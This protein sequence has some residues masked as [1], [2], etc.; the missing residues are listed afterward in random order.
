MVH[1]ALSQCVH[2][3]LLGHLVCHLIGI[4]RFC[5]KASLLMWA[6]AACQHPSADHAWMLPISSSVAYAKPEHRTSNNEQLKPA[7]PGRSIMQVY[8][9]ML[10]TSWRQTTYCTLLMLVPRCLHFIYLFNRGPTL[11]RMLWYHPSKCIM[12]Y[13]VTRITDECPVAYESHVW[14]DVHA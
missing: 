5:P 8:Y 12:L 11:H 2:L 14:K 3:I 4:D 13:F 7:P 9:R 10:L 1:V 6:P